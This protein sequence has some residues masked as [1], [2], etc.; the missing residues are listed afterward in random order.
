MHFISLSGK[1]RLLNTHSDKER[2]TTTG[3]QETRILGKSF[4]FCYIY[5]DFTCLGFV[6]LAISQLCLA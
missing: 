5:H 4:F 6:V 1:A 2:G 3:I